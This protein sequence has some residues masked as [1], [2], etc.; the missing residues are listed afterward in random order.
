MRKIQTRRD[1]KEAVNS[2]RTRAAKVTAQKE[3]TAANREVKKSVKTDERNV[4]EGLAQEAEKAEALK[5]YV[6]T[7]VEMLYS[8]FEEIWEK[9]EISAEWKE[10]YLIKIPKNGK[11]PMSSLYLRR[12][13]NMIHQTIY[14]YRC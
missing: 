13:V 2:S 3:H 9:E 12:G 10:C 6:N 14:Q 5:A 8:L 1:K 4:V 11:L 7:S